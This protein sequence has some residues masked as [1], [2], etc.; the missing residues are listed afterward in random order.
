MLI[1]F[2]KIT[3]Q[4]KIAYVPNVYNKKEQIFRNIFFATSNFYYKSGYSH[5][6]TN[7][8]TTSIPPILNQ[9][10][11][12]G[13]L[14]WSP[15]CQMPELNPLAADVMKL[16]QAEKYEECSSLKPLTRIRKNTTTNAVY[17][18]LQDNYKDFYYHKNHRLDCCYREIVRAGFNKT[19]DEKFK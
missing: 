4:I 19:A 8:T 5:L 11:P 6:H 1:F 9:S 18:V 14:V 3:N 13:F 17:L 2:Y 12:P 16:F 10:V 7:I 15:G